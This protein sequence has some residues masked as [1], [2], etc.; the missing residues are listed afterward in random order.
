M[1]QDAPTDPTYA[2]QITRRADGVE[3]CI[4]EL[5][6]YARAAT[7]EDAY[8]TLLA[9]KADLLDWTRRLGLADRLPPPQPPP[10]VLTGGVQG[11][12]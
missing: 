10:P 11:L 7:F 2:V 5:L 12:D 8:R 4:E 1:T 9:R 6:V 3:L